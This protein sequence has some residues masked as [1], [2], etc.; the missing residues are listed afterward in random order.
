MEQ[1]KKNNVGKT[2]RP[3]LSSI[4]AVT[5]WLLDKLFGQYQKNGPA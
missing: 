4:T 2:I 5:A 3:P 1:N